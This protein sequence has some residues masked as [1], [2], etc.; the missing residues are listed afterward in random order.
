MT[1]SV[2]L[3]PKSRALLSR[4]ARK[5]RTTKSEVIRTALEVLAREEEAKESRPRP[6]DLLRHAIGIGSGGGGHLAEDV[7]RKVYEML[8]KKKARWGK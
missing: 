7:S 5:R 1:I 6:Y 4:L 3:T 2:R 8:L